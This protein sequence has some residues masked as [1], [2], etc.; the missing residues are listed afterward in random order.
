MSGDVELNPGPVSIVQ[1][2]YVVPTD[3][4]V[5]LQARLEEQG[6]RPLEVGSDGACFF[7]SVAHQIYND[8]IHHMAVRAAG[9]QYLRNNPEAFID[10]ITEQSW[11]SY[12][13]MSK[14]NTWCDALVVQAVSQALNLTINI[15]ESVNGWIPVTVISPFSEQNDSTVINIGHLDETHYVSTVP[16]INNDRLSRTSNDVSHV[17]NQPSTVNCDTTDPTC[18]SKAENRRAY[19]RQLMK[20]KRENIAFKN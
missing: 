13:D 14:V 18:L 15:T 2:E 4:M 6:L 5:L 3:S 9:V 7:R 10:A 12:L 1:N 20:R 19:M 8:P 11:V 16:L 17:C